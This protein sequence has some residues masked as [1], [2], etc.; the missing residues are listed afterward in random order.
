L[1]RASLEAHFAGAPQ[2]AAEETGPLSECRGAFVSL[3]VGAELRGCIGQVAPDGPLGEL[4]THLAVAA[5]REDPRFQPVSR[6][7]LPRLQLEVSVLSEPAPIK[8]VQPGRIVVGRDG[9]V[10]RRGEK[11]GVLLPQVAIDNGW[12]AETFL[13]AA[14]RKAG[15][16][17]DAWREQ[18]AEVLVFQA[19][20]FG[21]GEQ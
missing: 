17:P 14:C 3:H 7:E 20:V 5:A 15:L 6:E 4:V 2:P 10:V 8:P 19:D 21:E 16:K 11:M 18:E 13:A 1:A 12:T 9:L